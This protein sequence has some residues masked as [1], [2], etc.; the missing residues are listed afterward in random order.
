M[1]SYENFRKLN[2]STGIE[3]SSLPNTKFIKDESTVKSTLSY[4][5]LGKVE[6]VPDIQNKLINNLLER[7]PELPE[8][9]ANSNVIPSAIEGTESISKSYSEILFEEKYLEFDRVLLKL[10]CLHWFVDGSKNAY[11]E[12][13]QDQPSDGKLSRKSFK[14]IH[15]KFKDFI[16]KNPLGLIA[17]EM[18]QL[19]EATLIL[20]SLGKSGVAKEQFEIFGE[21]HEECFLD[22]MALFKNKPELCTIFKNLPI[23]AQEHLIKTSIKFEIGNIIH[24]LGRAGMFS[25]IRKNKLTEFEIDFLYM[26]YSCSASGSKAHVNK[27]SSIVYTESTHRIIE[28]NWTACKLLI[29]DSGKNEKDVYASYLNVRAEWLKF[30]PD[31]A[32]GLVLTKIGAMF[33]LVTPEDGEILEDVYSELGKDIRKTI[34]VYLYFLECN[35]K[36]PTPKYIHAFLYNLSNNNKLSDKRD[37]RLRHAIQIGIRVLAEIYERYSEQLI[38]KNIDEKTPLDFTKFADIAKKYPLDFLNKDFV[39]DISFNGEAVLIKDVE[40][41]F[42]MEINEE[43]SRVTDDEEIFELEL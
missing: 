21:N 4:T 15:Q 34:T 25:E 37:A 33:R 19:M 5:S 14:A 9:Y 26:I 1:L 31:D 10:Q 8:W 39:K 32:Q 18:I 40:E 22:A 41:M 35:E 30:N 20:K 12:L 6:I 16:D 2:P 23:A 11:N 27:N 42:E 38:L 17:D 3:I 24:L 28:T 13:T 43:E 7:Y 36:V 29:E